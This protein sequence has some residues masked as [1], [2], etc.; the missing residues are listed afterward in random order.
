MKE[1]IFQIQELL[2]DRFYEMTPKLKDDLTKLVSL[3]D[4][5][6]EELGD[7]IENMI[8]A[9]E[10]Y[11]NHKAVEYAQFI[12]MLPKAIVFEHYCQFRLHQ[13]IENQ[14]VNELN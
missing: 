14:L 5:Q 9:N 8:E 13:S 11:S 12:T 4:E 3:L 7:S 6:T 1:T 10:V 2:K